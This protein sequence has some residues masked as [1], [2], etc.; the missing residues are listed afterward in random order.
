MD[1]HLHACLSCFREYRELIT[2]R[3]RLGVLAEQPLPKGALDGFT[4]EVMARVAVGEP[5]PRAEL[6][7]AFLWRRRIPR[8]A[9]AAALL[10]MVGVGVHQAG[11]IGGTT[12]PANS[13][14]MDRMGSAITMPETSPQGSS[15]FTA[16]API[17]AGDTGR[18]SARVILNPSN[19]VDSA[20]LDW[21]P[22]GQAVPGH[23]HAG[24]DMLGPVYGHGLVPESGRELRPRYPR[25]DR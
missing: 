6:P 1:E 13:T 3:G 19:H 15:P 5:G 21:L 2:M 10:L 18:T 9:A 12:Q 8:L 25:D 17:A 20:L 14:G 11:L 16:A 22:A 4:E 24:L 23:G 7:S